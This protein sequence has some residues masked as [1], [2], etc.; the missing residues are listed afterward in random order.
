MQGDHNGMDGKTTPME[1]RHIGIGADIFGAVGLGGSRRSES[2][3]RYARPVPAGRP[4]DADS[5]DRRDDSKR[6]VSLF[7]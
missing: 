3:C 4:A 7:G 6:A 2:S 1:I 5:A